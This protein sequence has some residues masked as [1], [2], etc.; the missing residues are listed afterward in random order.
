MEHACTASTWE[1]EAGSLLELKA[2][3]GLHIKFK[4]SQDNLVNTCL[5]GLARLDK[6]P[7]AKADEFY[8]WTPPSG[9]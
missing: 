6:G 8:L 7:A 2:N 4:A 5:T 3:R 1:T 9:S